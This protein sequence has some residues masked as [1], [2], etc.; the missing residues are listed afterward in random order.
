[1]AER[2]RTK[3]ERRWEGGVKKKEREMRERERERERNSLCDLDSLTLT[4]IS[5]FLM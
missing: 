4:D 2:E 1:M 3:R 5:K